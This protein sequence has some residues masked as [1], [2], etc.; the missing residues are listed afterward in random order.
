MC[1]SAVIQARIKNVYFGAY[2]AVNGAFGSKTD[3][4]TKGINPKVPIC[5]YI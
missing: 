3:M 1:A 2:D 5:V 4:K